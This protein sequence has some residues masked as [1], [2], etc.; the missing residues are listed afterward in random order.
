VNKRVLRLVVLGV[1]GVI[2]LT[3]GIGAA[4]IYTQ[5]VSKA[6]R[7]T[8]SQSFYGRNYDQLN[9]ND[10]AWVDAVCPPQSLQEKNAQ[11]RAWLVKPL[12]WI[13]IGFGIFLILTAALVASRLILNRTKSPPPST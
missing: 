1:V 8:I 12:K 11:F 2:V 5:D 9:D 13:G 7:E 3:I 4:H 10:R 6:T